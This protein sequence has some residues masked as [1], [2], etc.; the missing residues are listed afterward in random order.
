MSSDSAFIAAASDD[1][2]VRLWSTK[3][4]QNIGQA[5]EHV[6][7]LLCVAISPDGKWLVSGDNQGKVWFWS[8][9]NILKQH[10]ADERLQHKAEQQRQLTDQAATTLSTHR[11]Q[12]SDHSSTTNNSLETPEAS[13]S[14]SRSSVFDFLA[15]NTTGRNAGYFHTSEELLIQEI[16]V[17]GDHSDSYA[18]RSV[19]RARIFDWDNALQDAVKS[20]SI[21]P[22][23]MGYI[24]KGIALCGKEQLWDAMEAFDLAFVFLNRDPMTADILLLIKVCH[25]QYYL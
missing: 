1:K 25:S 17:D 8:L 5:L 3:T 9:K 22:S 4:H 15:T 14:Q 11:N 10:E 2:T 24:S 19:V 12:P 7:G 16:D 23:S 21:Q 6:A 13:S 20:I 18:N